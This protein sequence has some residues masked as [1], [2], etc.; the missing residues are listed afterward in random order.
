MN[1]KKIKVEPISFI[2]RIT[3]RLILRIL[4]KFYLYNEK[5]FDKVFH[6]SLPKLTEYYGRFTLDPTKTV[7]QIF[8]SFDYDFFPFTFGYRLNFQKYKDYILSNFRIIRIENLGI[9]NL[10]TSQEISKRKG[11]RGII[12][13]IS[14][15]I[16]D[17]FDS[18][19]ISK[20]TVEYWIKK[21][22]DY[23]KI[24][25]GIILEDDKNFFIDNDY[26]KEGDMLN[27]SKL[28]CF[29]NGVYYSK[30]EN[31]KFLSCLKY[32]KNENGEKCNHL[33][34]RRGCKIKLKK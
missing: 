9:S 12:N 30:L 33:H 17:Y 11:E 26:L 3:Y 24:Y 16:F 1:S 15:H 6:C 31:K 27:P 32:Y 5:P 34:L 28:I 20:E 13:H 29:K 2:G 23:V 21:K 7:F 14:F 4:K 8:Y 25:N 10:Y 19:I 18:N 22:I